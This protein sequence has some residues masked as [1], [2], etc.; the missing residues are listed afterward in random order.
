MRGLRYS[1]PL[2]AAL[3][4]GPSVPLSAQGIGKPS[5]PDFL[6]SLGVGSRSVAMGGAFSA[7]ADD[8]SATFWNPGRLSAVRNNQFM[9]DYRSVLNS[10]AI[11]KPGFSNLGAHPGQLRASFLGLVYPVYTRS[12]RYD[13]GTDKI[14]T[15]EKYQGHI[16]LSFTLGGYYNRDNE[17]VTM[18]A[19]IPNEVTSQQTIRNQFVNLSYGNK[20]DFGKKGRL[21][22]GAGI[23]FL[24]HDQHF[25]SL[26]RNTDSGRTT[27]INSFSDQS[28]N[29]SGTGY[30]LGLSYGI[31]PEYRQ[32]RLGLTYRPKIKIHFDDVQ[33]ATPGQGAAFADEVPSRT[34]VGIAYESDWGSRGDQI[35]TSF[36][37]QFFSTA[38]RARVLV[39]NI[40]TLAQQDA[41]DESANLHFGV[42]FVPVNS[43]LRYLF[44]R[45][46]TVYP[47]R[48][49]FRTNDNAAKS[50]TFYTNVVTVGFAIQRRDR[51]NNTTLSF[52]PS[53]E[54]LTRNGTV[55]WN[56]TA[57]LRF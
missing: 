55:L 3:L 16:G 35:R 14:L 56:L 37:G 36:E 49:G 54:I 30:Q 44:G 21:G 4:L 31:G 22:V 10:Q 47:I 26:D 32:W 7:I 23:V 39:G 50:Y 11:I 51:N 13:A 29:G 48:V 57:T 19:G 38:N 1:V 18:N 25:R 45:G 15:G 41:R 20:L 8:A 27:S 52:E 5:A 53:A 40:S 28:F 24:V 17:T 2:S 33:G 6:Q 43:P 46:N 42:E 34:S 9:L 12:R